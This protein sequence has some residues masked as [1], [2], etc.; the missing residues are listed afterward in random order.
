MNQLQHESS[1]YLQQHA[2][3]PV[4]W[5]AWKPEALERAKEEQK[6]ILVSIGYSTCHWCHVM[7]RE[8]FEN[9]AVAAIMNRH[10]VCI[11]VDREERPDVDAIYMEACQLLTGGGGWPLN[12]F[13]TPD[14]KP[15]YAGTYFPPQPAHSRPSWTQ[16][17][18]YLADIWENQRDAA[19]EQAER[20]TSR[21]HDS[22]TALLKPVSEQT[23]INWR[24]VFS[25]LQNQFDPVEG[26]FGGAPKFPSTMA[27]QLLL[28][29]YAIYRDPQALD[30]ALLSI[31]KMISGGIYDQLGG[32]FARYATD[33][34]WLVPHFEKMLYDN[35]L[36]VGVLSEAYKLLKD[37]NIPS[38]PNQQQL[39]EV[40]QITITETLTYI[41]CEM[42]N[43]EGGFFTAQDADS[44]GVEGKFYV[45]D[46]S[47]ID[48]ILKEDSEAF[49]QY[50]GVSESGNWEGKNILHRPVNSADH[51]LF[52]TQRK[53]L[54]EQRVKRIP[55]LLDTKVLLDMNALMCT[56][57]CQAYT[58]LGNEQYRQ[59]ALDNI[60]FVLSKLRNNQNGETGV[61][62][63]MHS[64]EQHFAF[65]DDYAYFIEALRHVY[66]ITFEDKYL[67]LAEQYTGYVIQQYWD[68]SSGMFYFS[69]ENQQDIPMRKFDVYDNATPSG[70]SVMAHNLLKLGLLLDKPAWQEMAVAMLSKIQDPALKYTV[71][72]SNWTTALFHLHHP[73]FEVAV[74]GPESREKAILIQKRFLPNKIMAASEQAN[75]KN[76]LLAGKEAGEKALYFLCQ[77]FACQ[78]PVDSEEGFWAL[79][80]ESRTADRSK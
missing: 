13:L 50:Y 30:H 49:C 27:I 52:G 28:E 46:K 32:G 16:L 21:I 17:L 2:H 66:D 26:G 67:D 4:H 59:M 25:N 8:S 43:E 42:T 68:N 61:P 58:A 57:C 34:A 78:A 36:L 20:L 44:E 9:E 29:Y 14:G 24:E 3:N 53:L 51:H 7:E 1:P 40:M 65:L 31:E 23:A 5:Y 74:V 33:R 79:V 10:F 62:P 22:G 41:K 56:A 63:L 45:W 39:A 75:D 47:E 64:K 15:F 72:F 73:S 18:M 77:N 80:S 37:P 69:S 12:C 11:K 55:P 54:L 48:Q 70:N 6:P 19:L 35:A 38:T 76:P 71:S 60:D